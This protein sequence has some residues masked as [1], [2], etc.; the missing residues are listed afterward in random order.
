MPVHTLDVL[1]HADVGV[2]PHI[3][4]ALLTQVGEKS[5]G[6]LYGPNSSAHLVGF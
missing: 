6:V 2:R 3:N 4:R 1:K 5:G